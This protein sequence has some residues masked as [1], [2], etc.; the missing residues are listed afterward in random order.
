LI[1][2]EVKMIKHTFKYL[3]SNGTQPV[4]K[5][6]TRELTRSAAI[7]FY[8]LDCSGGYTAE[9]RDCEIK[10]CPLFPFRPKYGPKPEA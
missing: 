9:V 6:A 4:E 7:K 10:L 5:V 8:C 3:K 1:D 2:D